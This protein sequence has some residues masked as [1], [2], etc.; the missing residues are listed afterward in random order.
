MLLQVLV[1]RKKKFKQK[2]WSSLVQVHADEPYR[3]MSTLQMYGFVF[4]WPYYLFIL[5]Y[6]MKPMFRSSSLYKNEARARTAT[7]LIAIH[8]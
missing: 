7:F 4:R 2:K 6:V 8:L 5:M 1:A 3:S